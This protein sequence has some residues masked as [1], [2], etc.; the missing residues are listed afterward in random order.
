MVSLEPKERG[1]PISKFWDDAGVIKSLETVKTWLMKNAKKV[2]N[3]LHFHKI[4][5]DKIL[6]V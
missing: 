2:N 3:D 5:K 6:I 4:N 1:G